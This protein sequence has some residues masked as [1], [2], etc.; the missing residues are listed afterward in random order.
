MSV[1]HRSVINTTGS[2]EPATPTAT[3][4]KYNVHTSEQLRGIRDRVRNDPQF[5]LPRFDRSIDPNALKDIATDTALQELADLIF[6]QSF[7]LSVPAIASASASVSARRASASSAE[8]RSMMR[9]VAEFTQENPMPALMVSAA[10]GMI[11]GLLIG[12][13]RRR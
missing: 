6:F 13:A 5:G 3:L 2:G 7:A 1:A 11:V 8:D 10:A 12:S 4:D 9:R